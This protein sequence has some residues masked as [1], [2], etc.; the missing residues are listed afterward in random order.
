MKKIFKEWRQYNLISLQHTPRVSSFSNFTAKFRR[1]RLHRQ[2][3]SRCN[4]SRKSAIFFRTLQS[5]RVLNFYGDRFYALS[6][7]CW[8]Y[9]VSAYVA[10][11]ILVRTWEQLPRIPRYFR[12]DTCFLLSVSNRGGSLYLRNIPHLHIFIIKY[13]CPFF[14]LDLNVYPDDRV[15]SLNYAMNY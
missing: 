4:G 14:I 13:V 12:Y 8:T 10:P 11:G 3:F 1:S 9:L 5:Y 7:T 2:S 6:R 15:S